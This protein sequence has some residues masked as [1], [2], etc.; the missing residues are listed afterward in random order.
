MSDKF[1]IEELEWILED[2]KFDMSTN[3]LANHDFNINLVA[4]L[5][6]MIKDLEE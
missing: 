3:S 6:R 1:T 4:K 5:E 2:I